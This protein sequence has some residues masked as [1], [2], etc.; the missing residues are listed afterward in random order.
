MDAK[1]KILGLPQALRET[2]EKGRPEYEAL[3]R[4]T[5]WVEQP[6]YM[7]GCGSSLFA[8]LSGAYAFEG[9]L[10]WPV[11]ARSAVDF[12]TYSL[13]VLRPRSIVLAISWSGESYETLAAA[14]AARTRGATLLAL[15]NSPTSTLGKMADGVFLLRAGEEYEPV[16]KV[17][18]Q[19]AA[20]SY[21][22]LVAAR[23][24]KRPHTQLDLLEEEFAKLPVHVEWVLTQLQDAVR[25]FASELKGLQSLFVVGGGFYYPT[26]LQWARLLTK[27]TGIHAEGFDP[28]EFRHGPLEILKRDA[29]VVFLSGSRCRIKKELNPLVS[30]V[31]KAGAKIFSV[32]DTNDRELA[33]RSTLAM[34]LPVLTEMVG[35]TLTLT[36]LQWVAYHTADVQGRDPTRL[37]LISKSGRD[38][39]RN[40]SR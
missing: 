28:T 25:P 31:K 24:L 1:Q 37:R 9:L 40:P 8:G 18:C 30:W 27:L 17:V 12:E 14:Q 7:V 34:L 11:V 3:V 39:E 33:N 21:V 16:T 32:T 10:G 4:R 20:L 35:S 38:K 6:I 23:I 22:S 15:T 36:L 19:Q 2:L 29:A 26:A 5:R 13:S